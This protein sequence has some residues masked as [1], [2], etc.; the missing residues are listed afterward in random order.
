MNEFAFDFFEKV[1][2]G[3]GFVAAR[4]AVGTPVPD[5]VALGAA[6]LP[7]VAGSGATGADGFAVDDGPGGTGPPA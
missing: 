5:G 7:R 3:A 2:G 6:A 1:T 4:A